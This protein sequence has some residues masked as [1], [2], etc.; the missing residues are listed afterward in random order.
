MSRTLLRLFVLRLPLL[1]LLA[2]GR[3]EP[4]DGQRLMC[5]Q[6]E[7]VTSDHLVATSRIARWKVELV[8]DE[9]RGGIQ[10]YH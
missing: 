1:P 7:Q 8:E 3:I 2:C 10:I 9:D 6:V 4:V 5:Q